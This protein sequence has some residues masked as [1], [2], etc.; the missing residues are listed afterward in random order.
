MTLKTVILTSLLGS[1]LFGV[2]VAVAQ[3][4]SERILSSADSLQATVKT[5]EAQEEKDKQSISDLKQEQTATKQKAK[6]ARR[7]ER[8]ANDAASQSRD[9]Y[10]TEKKAQK[11]RKSADE[12]AEK[13][14]KSRDRSDQN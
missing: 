6:E 1:A 5:R 10:R 13:A 9:A 2:N 7:I 3:E 12:Q 8:E 4:R 11:A 14:S